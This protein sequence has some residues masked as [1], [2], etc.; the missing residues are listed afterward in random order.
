[1]NWIYSIAFELAGRSQI[2]A[3]ERA[4]EGL[5][6]TVDEVNRSINRAGQSAQRF[7]NNASGGFNRAAGAVRNWVGGLAIGLATM[8][9]INAAAA[10][11]ATNIAIDFGTGG[12]GAESVEFVRQLSDDLG[13]NLLASRD[14]FKLLAGSLRGTQLEGQATKDIFESIA[15]AGAGMRLPAEDIK[16][17]YLAV[18]QIA[19]K[20]KV[21]AEELRGQLGERLP[22][23]FRIAAAAMGVTQTELNKLLETGKVTAEDFLPKFAAQ[24]K[25]EFGPLAASVANS[26]AAN[27]ERWKTAVYEL[28]VA[29]GTYLLPTLST[30]LSEYLIPAVQWIGEHIEMLMH[31]GAA[32]GIIYGAVKVYTLYVA[33]TKAAAGAQMLLNLAMS[34][35]P[36]GLVVASLAALVAAVVYA[37]NNF[38]GFRSFIFGMWEV[39]K[40]TASII[41]DFL[42]SPFLSLGKIIA[43]VF[44]LDKTM[45]AEGIADASALLSSKTLDIGERLG[46]AMKKGIAQGVT[47]FAEE[48]GGKKKNAETA[49]FDMPGASAFN[50]DAKNE[51]AKTTGGLSGITGRSQ[52]K[53]VNITLGSLVEEIKIIADNVEEGTDEMVDIILRK[54]TQV[55][56]SANQMQ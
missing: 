28:Q 52:T 40:E 11:D 29:F 27:M 44:T 17:A 13:V 49:G 41:F 31:L 30:L 56:N 14:G 5:D 1:M 39:L 21:Q 33:V 12:N 34:L 2:T 15:T 37:W 54:L 43:G 24:L 48:S 9:S 7:G 8:S 36:I 42:I 10:N 47:S 3:A 26:P 50:S 22:G 4:A 35:N 6:N 38:A 51:N 32:F 20:G 46:G 18:S 19:S 25:N 53:N 23:A 45:I 55:I 16:G